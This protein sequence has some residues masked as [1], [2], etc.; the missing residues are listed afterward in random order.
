MMTVPDLL[1]TR[2][3]AIIEREAAADERCVSA[4]E[5]TIQHDYLAVRLE[6][7]R[8][9]ILVHLGIRASTA[10]ADLPAF[11]VELQRIIRL[12]FD[13]RPR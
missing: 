8:A 5:L 2:A 9:P 10:V 6:V 4:I 11:D 13:A 7:E 3:I 1:E 12:I